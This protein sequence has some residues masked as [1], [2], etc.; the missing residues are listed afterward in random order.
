MLRG[1]VNLAMPGTGADLTTLTA[2]TNAT[3]Y[4]GDVGPASMLTAPGALL[5]SDAASPLYLLYLPNI[6]NNP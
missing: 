4:V 3:A 5:I 1:G 2:F 6:Q